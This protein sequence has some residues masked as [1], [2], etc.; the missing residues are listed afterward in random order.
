MTETTSARLPIARVVVLIVLLSFAFRFMQISLGDAPAVEA[1]TGS[2]G[3]PRL[4][5][6][7]EWLSRCPHPSLALGLY[8]LPDS[9]CQPRQTVSLNWLQGQL[10]APSLL[11]DGE[12]LELIQHPV[13][14][15]C[16]AVVLAGAQ[17]ARAGWLCADTLGLYRL[18][19]ADYDS[20]AR[21]QIWSDGEWAQVK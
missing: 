7:I 14:L 11:A 17:S 6:R 13:R 9:P 8:A 3:N 18:D 21:W 5:L 16:G 19:A 2:A 4:L 1:K 20:G 12:Y 15:E 10:A